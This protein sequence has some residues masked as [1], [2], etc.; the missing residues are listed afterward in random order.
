LK[1]VDEYLLKANEVLELY[2][3]ESGRGGADIEKQPML[4]GDDGEYDQ[5]RNLNQQ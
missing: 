1:Q 5:T 2:A 4:R 3:D